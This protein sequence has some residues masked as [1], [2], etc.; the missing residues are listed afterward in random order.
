MID[1]I[2]SDTTGKEYVPSECVR[3]VNMKQLAAYMLHG[4][5][6]LDFY[7]SRDF[8]TDTPILVGIVNIKDSSEVYKKWRNFDLN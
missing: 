2:R 3:I 1:T 5:E 8:K 6:L 7:A 4:V